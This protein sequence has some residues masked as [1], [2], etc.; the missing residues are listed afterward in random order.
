M[1]LN[2]LGSDDTVLNILEHLSE[3]DRLRLLVTTKAFAH[4]LL[5][6]RQ[7]AHDTFERLY[8]GTYELDGSIR[9][10]TFQPQ[11]C[12]KAHFVHRREG[13]LYVHTYW[14]DFTPEMIRTD[15]G[16]SKWFFSPWMPAIEYANKHKNQNGKEGDA[17][18][19]FLCNASQSTRDAKE[20]KNRI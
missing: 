18:W 11:G 1:K 14:S 20:L 2:P 15:Y 7:S 16:Q 19:R 17:V 4:W 10:N 5:K 8:D 3:H 12:H 9:F 6:R 13:H